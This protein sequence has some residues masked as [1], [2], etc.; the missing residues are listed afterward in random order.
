MPNKVTADV[1]AAIAKLAEEN[2]ERCQAWLDQI[3]AE[4]PSKAFD[5][6]LKMCEYHIPKLARS[7]VTGKDGG[8]IVITASNHDE[9]L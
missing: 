6:F 1:R 5:L 7:E 3:A 8:A 4:D 2:V 9:R